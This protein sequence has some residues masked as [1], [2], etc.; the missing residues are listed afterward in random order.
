MKQ[1][2][3]LKEIN[4]DLKRL[5]LERQIAWEEMKGLKED[6]KESIQPH[7]LFAPILSWAKQYGILYL[8][9]LLFTK[10]K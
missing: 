8:I 2:N 7:N 4:H 3:S 5:S 9:R 6:F 1:Y 10:K